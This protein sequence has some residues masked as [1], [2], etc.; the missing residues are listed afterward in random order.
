MGCRHA[1]AIGH[2]SL[3]VADI[4]IG[5]RE[6][7]GHHAAQ[8]QHEGGD[9]IDLV[10]CERLG[11]RPRHGAVNVVPQRG[12]R[13]QFHERGA[14]RIGHLFQTGNAPGFDIFCRGAANERMEHVVGLA[15]HAVAGRTLRL[16]NLLALRDGARAVWQAFEIRAHVDVPRSYFLHGR[17]PADAGVSWVLLGHH[18]TGAADQR[19]R[20]KRIKP[21]EHF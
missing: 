11:L 6:I 16:P 12:K 9:C 3:H 20:H 21:P 8:V 2:A 10:R 4:F 15:K 17:H 18:N 13:G 1:V 19:E 7:I 14:L 5:Q